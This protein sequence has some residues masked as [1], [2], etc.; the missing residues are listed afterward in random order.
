MWRE[1]RQ[2]RLQGVSVTIHTPSTPEL[3]AKIR[4]IYPRASTLYF[5]VAIERASLEG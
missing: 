2:E 4:G 5:A 3:N 1:P